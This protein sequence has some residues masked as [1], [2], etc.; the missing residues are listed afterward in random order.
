VHDPAP[1]GETRAL[2]EEWAYRWLGACL[3]EIGDAAAT[4]GL[5]ETFAPGRPVPAPEPSARTVRSWARSQGIEVSDRGR[6]PA[7]LL[8]AYAEAQEATP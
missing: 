1:A 6:V 5:E 2:A 3:A 8:R 7:D 4:A